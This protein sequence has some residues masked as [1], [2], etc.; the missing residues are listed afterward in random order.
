MRCSYAT[1]SPI[2]ILKLLLLNINHIHLRHG[3]DEPVQHPRDRGCDA[4]GSG[5]GDGPGGP[6]SGAEQGAVSQVA[7]D[8]LR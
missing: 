3:Y 6:Q 4:G 7:L 5:G 2:L 8:R 1:V